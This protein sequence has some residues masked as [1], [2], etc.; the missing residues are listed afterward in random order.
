MCEMVEW[1]C[2]KCAD[3]GV[4]VVGVSPSP[5]ANGF[6]SLNP[7]FLI[8]KIGVVISGGCYDDRM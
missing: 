1:D 3:S 7:N 2:G 5:G 4:G 8:R 6:M